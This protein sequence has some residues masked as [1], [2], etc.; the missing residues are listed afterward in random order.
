MFSSFFGVDEMKSLM[1]LSNMLHG[2]FADILLDMRC[3]QAFSRQ[4]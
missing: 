2:I 1:V 4:I 3:F